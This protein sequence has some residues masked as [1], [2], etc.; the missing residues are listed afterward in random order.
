[1]NVLSLPFFQSYVAGKSQYIP[2]LSAAYAKTI[3]TESLGLSLIQSLNSTELALK[4]M[5][6]QVRS[7]DFS[8]DFSKH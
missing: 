6:K 3:S 1:M 4:L 2:Y 8:H 5:G 7:Q